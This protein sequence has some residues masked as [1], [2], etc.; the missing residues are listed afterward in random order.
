MNRLSA[1]LTA[2]VDVRKSPLM[3]VEKSISSRSFS[4][5]F[6]AP[7]EFELVY[8]AQKTIGMLSTSELERFEDTING[9]VW[10]QVAVKV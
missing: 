5:H 6:D 2:Y 7:C 3:I 8:K 10:T 1:V 4:R 9:A